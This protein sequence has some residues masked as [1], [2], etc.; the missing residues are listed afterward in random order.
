MQNS[1][2][3]LNSVSLSEALPSPI[4]N[5]CNI[6]TIHQANYARLSTLRTTSTELDSQIRDTLTLLTKTRSELIATPATTLPAITNPLSSYSELLKYAGRISKYTLPPSYRE[7]VQ[8]PLATNASASNDPPKEEQTQTQTNGIETTT[9]VLAVNGSDTQTQPA[10]AAEVDSTTLTGEGTQATDV[11][12]VKTNSKNWAEFLGPQDDLGWTPW[13]SPYA[14]RNGA[15]ASIQILVDQGLDPATFDPEKSA[16]LEAERKR[17]MEEE[18]L[19]REQEQ[20]R[21]E[22][23][24]RREMERRTS[25]SGAR[26]ERVQEQPKVFQLETFDDDDDDD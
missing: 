8:D 23:E 2:R 1:A 14:I 9:P 15:L 13:P 18:D 24:R 7:P 16:E 10:M 22:E 6:V 25:A 11:S 21:I 26:P 19:K 12:G 5:Q 20:A 4:L 17:V 3:V